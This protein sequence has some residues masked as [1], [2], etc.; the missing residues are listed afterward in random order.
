MLVSPMRPKC[1]RDEVREAPGIRHFRGNV[2]LSTTAK[3]IRRLF[4]PWGCVD[5]FDYVA[6]D[7]RLS[8]REEGDQ[9]A[10]PTYRE[11]DKKTEFAKR[12][13]GEAKKAK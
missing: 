6:A 12:E 4:G 1:I 5:F 8:F 9:A 13:E 3:K 7:V 11:A 2:S 10:G